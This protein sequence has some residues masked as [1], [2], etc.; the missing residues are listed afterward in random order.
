MKQDNTIKIFLISLITLVLLSIFGFTYAYFSL[1]IEGTPKDIVM[2]TGDLRLEYKDETELSLADAVP[3]DS[4]SKVITVKNVG[5]KNATYSLYWG[6]LINTIENYELHVTLNCKSYTNYGETT[7]TESGTCD[8]IYRAVPI[9]S[10]LTT[11]N[12][13]GNIS[14]DP[15]ITHEYTVTVTFDNKP[16]SQNDNLNKTFTGKIGI[17]EYTAPEVYNCTFDG[18]LVQGVE[19]VSGQYT[20]RYKQGGSYSNDGL[21]WSPIGNDGWGVQLTDKESTDPVTS[22][23]CTYINNKPIVDMSYMFYR[24]SATTLDVSNFDTSNVTNMRAM[25]MESK[26]TTIKGL[27]NFDTSKVTDMGSMFSYSQATT[28]DLSS[29]NTNNVIN[30]DSMFHSAKAKTIDLSSFDT[31][32]V[33]DMRSMFS[34]SQATTLDV[35]NFDTSNVTNMRAM[36][37][38][39]K[40]TTIKGLNN[41]DTSKVTNMGSMF[42]Y[43]QATTLDLSSFNTSKVTDM[44]SMFLYSA[45]TTINLSSFDTSKVT[46]MGMMFSNCQA[47]SLDLSNFNTSKVTNMGIMFS[48]CQATS[49]DLS[50]FN[51]SNVTNMSSMF[52]GSQ[53]TTLDLSSF[54]TSNVTNMSSMFYGNQATSLDLSSFNTSNVTNMDSMFRSAKAK[55]IDV[56]S[57]NTS[58]VNNMSH[59][60]RDSKATTLD[61]SSF[62][63]SNVTNMSYMFYFSNNLKNIYAS[64]KFVTTNVT[65][66]T[67]MFFKSTNIVGGAGTV[68]DSTKVDKTYARIDGGTNSPGYFTAKQ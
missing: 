57:F 67:N 42:S 50:N 31:I 49:L 4:I 13:K 38:E 10:T 28:L 48:N 9:S 45:A 63:T 66:S 27:N 51:T 20:Y 53:A 8:N 11:S 47:T 44:G 18:D 21:A 68:Y 7:Q 64:S 3:G 25:F 19:F 1:E 34:Y 16:Y 36:F 46:N 14:I 41:F 43:S 58:N 32:N 24:S 35:S 23:L 12:I 17:Q 55:R 30:M 65:S 37:M 60:F 2:T 29:F 26:V 62:N 6:N 61:L 59:M 56:S 40:A 22:K 33:T 52:Y 54:N 15:N 39:S 5:T